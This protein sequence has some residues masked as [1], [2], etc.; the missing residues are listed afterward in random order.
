MGTNFQVV[1]ISQTNKHSQNIFV[2]CIRKTL[3]PYTLTV[4]TLVQEIYVCNYAAFVSFTA[5]VIISRTSLLHTAVS[6]ICSRDVCI[7][8]TRSDTQ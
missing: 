5:Q 3:Y 6:L 2:I 8:M 4:K 7:R 1:P